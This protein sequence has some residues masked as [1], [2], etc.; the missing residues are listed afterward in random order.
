MKFS[1]IPGHESA[2]Q[3]LRQMA[4]TRRLPH[5]LLIEGPEGIGKLSLARAFAQYI[6]CE[7]PTADG[8]P[9]GEC[10]PCILHQSMNHIDTTFVYPVVKTDGMNT[11]PTSAD[12][13]NE[14]LEYLDGRLYMDL[15]Q[16][17]STFAKKNAQP[18]TYVT[19]S[20]RLIHS[21][22]FTSHVSRYKI[23]IWW[24]P[25]RMNLDAANKLLKLIEEPYE[26]TLFIMVSDNPR[27]ILPTIYSRVQ[28][29]RLRRL[30]DETVARYLQAHFDLSHT[31]AMAYAHLAEGN[32]TRA[33]D[34]LNQSKESAENFD[35][36]V[37]LMRLAY[38]RNVH[39]LRTWGD[40]LAALGRDREVR[41]YEYAI[42][43]I[44]ENFIYNFQ[45]PQINYMTAPEQQ[46][47]TR[48]ARFIHEGNV[49]K[50]IATFDRARADIEGHANGKIV[51]LDVAIKVIMLLIQK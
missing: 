17:T 37:R 36:F 35:L 18:L 11:A 44:R 39:Q 6:H 8:E 34:A 13:H 43:L 15:Q 29:L 46:F 32:V 12:F 40:E 42:R 47:S 51:N 5:A 9:C 28:R 24:L 27:D 31:D 3:R 10:Q 33:I 1:D 38:Q 45:L 2:K 20:A 23:V 16:W 25:E 30:D 4:D 50:L 41:F 48:F 19:E 21:L 26:D 49:E 14:W 7:H 22:A